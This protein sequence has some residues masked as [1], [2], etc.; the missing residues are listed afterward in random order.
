MQN[1][2]LRINL[3]NLRIK[4]RCTILHFPISF[5]AHFLVVVQFEF[6]RSMLSLLDA[7]DCNH[8]ETQAADR[9]GLPAVYRYLR[10]LQRPIQRR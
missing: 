6:H 4:C 5:S 3:G 1:A 9:E 2:C 8:A 7:L 10:A